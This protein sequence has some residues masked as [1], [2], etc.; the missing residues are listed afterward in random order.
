MPVAVERRS[1]TDRR[2]GDRRE[3]H[4]R[5]IVPDRRKRGASAAPAAASR[6]TSR[7]RDRARRLPEDVAGGAG[8]LEQ[9]LQRI[10]R[11]AWPNFPLPVRAGLIEALR[12]VLEPVVRGEAITDKLRRRCEE[13]V[14]EWIGKYR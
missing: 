4:P 10:T 13:V 1:G 6:L 14:A 2:Q 8:T 11:Q 5:R 7:D 3:K 12:S 9:R